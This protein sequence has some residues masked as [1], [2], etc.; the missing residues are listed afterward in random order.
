LLTKNEESVYN[1]LN[2]LCEEDGH[3]VTDFS[4]YKIG[5]IAGIDTAQTVANVIEE[6]EKKGYV[7]MKARVGTSTKEIKIL[8]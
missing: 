4:F 7:E 2:L 3:C 6:L 1:V 8:K 5:E